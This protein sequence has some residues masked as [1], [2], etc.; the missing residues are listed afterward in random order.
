[1]K[2]KRFEKYLIWILYGLGIAIL[3]YPL[4]SDWIN[5][6]TQ[7]TAIGT[8]Q[9]TVDHNKK[10]ADNL[11]HEAHIYNAELFDKG[12]SLYSG[13]GDFFHYNKQL[14]L[15][16]SDVMGYIDIPMINVKL[17]IY[18]GT[19]Q[20]VLQ[21]GVGQMEGT[22]LPVGGINTHSVL[23]GHTGLPSGGKL[24]TDL[25]D[26]KVGNLFCINVLN[27]KLYY[28]VDQIKVVKPENIAPLAIEK[29]RDLVTLLTC[30]PYGINSHRLLVRGTRVKVDLQIKANAKVLTPLTATVV[31]AVILL[32]L[33]F[34]IVWLIKGV[35]H[36]KEKN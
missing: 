11:Y 14:L 18:H 2:K 31:M 8:Y 21:R 20:A 4:V 15:P 7:T 5:K 35:R 36:A 29:G 34:L 10:R 16:Q 1:M 23:T 26:L 33:E 6:Q 3:L 12:E 32:S 25:D 22:S 19:D 28:Q 17:P 9:K 30:T 13:K 24:F 27:H